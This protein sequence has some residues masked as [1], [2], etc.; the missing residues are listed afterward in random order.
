MSLFDNIK[1]GNI[2]KHIAVIMDGNGRWAK[3]QGMA[4][5]FGH[6]NALTSIRETLTA[7]S[8][9]GTKA[10]TLYVFSTENWNRPKL[11]VDG[12]MTLLTKAIRKE[13][14]GFKKND[15]KVQ[16]V[17]KLSDLPKKAAETLQEVIDLTQDHKTITLTLCLSYGS[18]EEITSCIQNIAKQVKNGELNPEEINENVIHNNLYTHYLPDVDLMIRTSGEQRLSNYLLWQSAY[19]ELYFTNTLWPDFRREDL[20]KAVYE[21]QNRERRFG[22]TSEQLEGEHEQIT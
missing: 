15:V 7:A 12:L 5:L 22:K 17:G 6:N 1:E 19:A 4:R 20:F 16:A 3:K 8:D 13:V 14:P 10:V 2:P 18:R 9:I 21:Y 11:E